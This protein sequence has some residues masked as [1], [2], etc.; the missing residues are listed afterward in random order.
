M[1]ID[2]TGFEYGMPSQIEMLDHQCH[3]LS[4]ENDSLRQELAVAHQ[5]LR[6]LIDINQSLNNQVISESRRANGSHL[7]LVQ[8]GNRLR[9]NHG[10]DI[11]HWFTD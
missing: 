4:G 1:D 9:C 5:N 2:T 7:R 8:I 3:L 10:I 6:K 11:T